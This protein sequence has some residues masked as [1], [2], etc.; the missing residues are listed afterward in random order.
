M[1]PHTPSSRGRGAGGLPLVPTPIHH[2]DPRCSECESPIPARS[3]LCHELLLVPSA[4]PAA[5]GS[6]V[7][8]KEPGP[9]CPAPARTTAELSLP[10]RGRETHSCPG[11]PWTPLWLCPAGVG[12]EAPLP[13]VSLG[14]EG[15]A[16]SL[17]PT[18]RTG[19]PLPPFSVD[20]GT[21]RCCCIHPSVSARVQNFLPVPTTSLS[22]MLVDPFWVKWVNVAK[23]QFIRDKKSQVLQPTGPPPEHSMAPRP[24]WQWGREPWSLSHRCQ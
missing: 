21:V 3:R 13:R 10:P 19:T 17:H 1:P 24:R 22:K 16:G 15:S 2:W 23:V 14:R 7:S 12:A 6:C 11:G 5:A 20:G 18:I 4:A 8:N 9:H